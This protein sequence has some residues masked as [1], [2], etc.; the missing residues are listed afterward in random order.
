MDHLE[1]PQTKIKCAW[2]IAMQIAW[3]YPK[4]RL[5]RSLNYIPYIYNQLI[6]V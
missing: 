3:A 5:R 4:I 6:N 1:M 2:I